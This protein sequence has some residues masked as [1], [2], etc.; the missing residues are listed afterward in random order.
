MGAEI[1]LMSL[2]LASFVP[3]LSLSYLDRNVIVGNSLIGV[4]SPETVGNVGTIWYDHLLDALNDADRGGRTP[5]GHRRPHP[6]RG[7]SQQGRRCP[8]L[9]CYRTGATAVRSLDSTRDSGC[10]PRTYI[11]T[12]ALNVISGDVEQDH[13][14]QLISV[15]HPSRARSTGSF[16]GR[17][18]S[19]RM[20]DPSGDR[21]GFDVVVGNPPWEEVT[22]EELGFYGMHK[23]GITM[24]C[25]RETAR[26]H[27][28]SVT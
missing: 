18:R 25:Q 2:W 1:A 6:R 13:G 5:S 27:W 22:V 23:P 15:C 9:G 11:E 24:D 7:R 19:P 26:A 10:T 12:H 28:R 14:Q 4:L 3:G 20:F 8:S 16:T 17:W 21:P